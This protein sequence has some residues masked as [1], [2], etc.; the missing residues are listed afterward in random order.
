MKQRVGIEL[1]GS[2]FMGRAHTF[3]YRAVP[4]LFDVG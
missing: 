4:G 3:A 1:I 2:G